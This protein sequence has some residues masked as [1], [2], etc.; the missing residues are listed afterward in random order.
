MDTKEVV[1]HLRAL[2][3]GDMDPFNPNLGLCYEMNKVAYNFWFHIREFGQLSEFWEA[4]P[5]FS[6][7]YS[8]PLGNG[9]EDYLKASDAGTQWNVTTEYGKLRREACGALAT[10]IEENLL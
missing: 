7:S 5:G 2:A 3:D 10:F 8:Y 9:R 1:Q 4:Y 6:G